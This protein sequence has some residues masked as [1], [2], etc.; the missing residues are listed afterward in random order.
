V[1]DASQIPHDGGSQRLADYSL[2]IAE[3][4]DRIHR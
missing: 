3:A 4:I 1:S 2:H